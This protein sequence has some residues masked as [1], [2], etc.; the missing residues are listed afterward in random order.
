MS[1]QMSANLDH[2]C[3]ADTNGPKDDKVYIT[4]VDIIPL[5]LSV[6]YCSNFG[7]AQRHR[8]RDLP[9]HS[10]SYVQLLYSLN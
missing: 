3:E 5:F 4:A 6:N 10:I 8:L 1:L 2:H 7:V 9:Q